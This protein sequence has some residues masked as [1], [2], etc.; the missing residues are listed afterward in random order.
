[1]NELIREG[2][3]S[4][5]AHRLRAA[6]AALGIVAGVGT[7]LA[8][9]AITNGAQRQAMNEIGRL[10]IHNVIVRADHSNERASR[11]GVSIDGDDAIAIGRE[12]PRAEIAMLRSTTGSV[13]LGRRSVDATIAGV[14]PAWSITAN[15]TIVRGRWLT[16]MDGQWRTAVVSESL[17]KKL[18]GN[19][20]PLGERVEAAGEWRAIVGVVVAPNDSIFVPFASL[21]LTL[22]NGD[23]GDALDQIVI[24]VG[25][26]SDVIRAGAAVQSLLALRHDRDAAFE[27]IVPQALLDAR[28]RSGRNFAALLLTIGALTLFVSGI[29]IMNIMVAS[30]TER[31]TEIG[32][33]R[34]FGARRRAIVFQF[35]AEASVLSA[36]AGLAGIPIGVIAALAAAALGGWPIAVTPLSIAI[37]LA[38]A[39]IVGLSAGIYPARL[40]SRLTPSDALRAQQ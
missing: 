20:D 5:L 6:L 12:L 18:T 10:G 13:K 29:G 14:T 15:L 37:A 23:T 24:K 35:A 34:A 28:L 39:L 25:D 22:V 4:L 11:A 31:T 16:E 9:L 7:I 17:A 1:M 33:R 2:I 26:E 21:D 19:S 8:V 38:V 3:E 32:V 27:V 40:A 36:A 30:V